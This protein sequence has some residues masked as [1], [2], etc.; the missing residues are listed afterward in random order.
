MRTIVDIPQEHIQALDVIAQKKDV[1]RAELMRRAVRLY[2]S[3]DKQKKSDDSL[4]KYYGFLKNS[5]EAFNGL[6][7][8]DYQNKMRGEWDQRDEMYGKWGLHDSP[9]SGFK[10]QDD[11][12]A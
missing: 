3:E 5:P 11:N 2:L 8:M 10:P 12:G 4:D 9:Q 7:G 1:S 6:K